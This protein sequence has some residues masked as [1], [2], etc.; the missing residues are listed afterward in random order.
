MPVSKFVPSLAVAVTAI[1]A[2]IAWA[3]P[4]PAAY[5]YPFQNP[6]LPIEER[7]SN[8]LSLMTLDEKIA[9]LG[10]RPDVPRL[11]IQGSGHVE[12]LHGLALG[13]PAHWGGNLSF[14]PTTQF[15]QAVGLGETWDPDLV[16]QAAHVE[17]EEARYTFQNPSFRAPGPR[18]PFSG[19]V[20][21]APNSDLA[22]DPRWGRTEESYGE[23]PFLTGTMATAFVR[24]LQG[25]NPKYW[26][27]AALLKHFLAN[28]NEDT[29]T[30]SSSNF[31][32]RLF[33]EY[34]SAPFRMAI[35]KGGSQAFMTAYNS[36]NGV[37]MMVSPILRNIVLKDWGFNGIIC[38]DGG[39]LRALIDDHHYST[40]LD[41]GAAAAIHAGINQFLDRY[42]EPV[43]SALDKG[44]L[45]PKELDENLRGVFRVMIRL[46]LL[47]P[48]SEVPYASIGRAGASSPPWLSEEHKKI[49]L[50][51]TEKSIVLLKNTGSVLPLDRNALHSIAVL[52]PR[53][54]EVDLDWYSGRPPFRITPLEGIR[55]AA[56]HSL[57]IHYVAYDA[58]PADAAEAARTSD[59]AIVFVGNHPSCNAGWGRCFDPTEGKEGIDRK[60]IDLNADQE[61]LVR[62]VYAA[63][64]RTVVVLVSSFPYA[65]AWEK[66]HIPAILHMAHNSEEEGT[67]VAEAL[68]GDIDPGGRL[69]AT[70]P[71]SLGQL[72]PLTD[73][74]IRDGHT[75]MYFKGEPLFPFGYG[76]SYTTFRYA[77]LRV[78]ASQLRPG[79]VATVKVDVTDTGARA[80]DEVVQVYVKHMRSKA[81]RPAAEL[82][83]FRRVALRPGETN[84]VELPL[85]S[86]ALRYWDE[87]AG[88]WVLENDQVEI[89]AGP[90]SADCALNTILP[91]GE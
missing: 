4:T 23:D 14:I 11:G 16:R 50:E 9:C 49:A 42:R 33:H 32:P 19:I 47:D 18:L 26:E 68:F 35:E 59:A 36:V 72:P 1:A 5:K 52:G 75:Y 82:K 73:Y 27:T 37:P 6:S 90:S 21:R 46:G 57:D 79:G 38:T 12:G 39:A 48:P 80:G 61:R 20:V 22:R 70:W 53:A 40:S 71:A 69:V 62:A 66:E 89:C 56:G 87:A 83:A 13:G 63:N 8:I 24:G 74:D 78:G 10:A 34:Y 30:S 2:S 64:H 41:E 86:D 77:N 7:V 17:A 44:I 54:D 91:A 85:A 60:S 88:R 51:V 55:K 45:T 43:Q 81:P 65:I 15:P 76:L 58:D 31:D 28:E 25:D 3:Q 84:T 67:A 29:R